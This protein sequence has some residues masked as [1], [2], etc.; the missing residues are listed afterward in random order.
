VVSRHAPL[1]WWRKGTI[2][3][4]FQATGILRSARVHDH[5][6]VFHNVVGMTRVLQE[7]ID[8]GY[9]VTPEIIARLSPYKTEHINRFGHYELH[10][11]QVPQ[12]ITEELRF[13][14]ALTVREV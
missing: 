6:V 7:L 5:L 4:D 14:P 11:D 3:S 1:T 9:Q 10:F 12:P 13:S 2:L 8:E